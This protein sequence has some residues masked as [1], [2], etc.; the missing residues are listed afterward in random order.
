[1]FSRNGQQSAELRLH[2]QELGA[3]QIS[4]KMEDNQAQ[5]HFASAHSQVRA[6]LEAAMPSLRHALAESGVQLGQ[7]SVGSEGN[8]SRHSSKAS[9]SAGR[10]CSRPTHLR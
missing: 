9:K 8:G 3:L 7:S 10:H 4:L 5:L 6:A 1:M 2:P